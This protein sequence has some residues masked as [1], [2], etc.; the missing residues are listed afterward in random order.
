MRSI[1]Y[2]DIVS[3]EHEDS[4]MSV[5]EGLDKAVA[6]LRQVLMFQPASK[7]KAFDLD[8]RFK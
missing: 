5:E 1:G 4:Y 6:N 3:I 2:D 8:E 7:P